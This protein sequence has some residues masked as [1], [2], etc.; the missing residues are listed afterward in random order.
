MAAVLHYQPTKANGAAGSCIRVDG[1]AKV[2]Y[3][4]RRDARR[5]ARQV[6]LS[7]PNVQAYLCPGCGSYH[8]GRRSTWKSIKASRIVRMERAIAGGAS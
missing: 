7:V 6:R 8:V 4:S 1:V 5:V 2:R 3:G